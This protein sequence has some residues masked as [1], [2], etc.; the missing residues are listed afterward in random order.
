MYY[1]DLPQFCYLLVNTKITPLI[2]T[3]WHKNMLET[4]FL[5]QNMIDVILYVS[6][7]RQVVA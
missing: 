5:I 6:I 1:Y 7:L 4:E 2:I 3:H